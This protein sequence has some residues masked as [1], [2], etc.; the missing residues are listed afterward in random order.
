M[1]SCC[2]AFIICVCVAIENKFSREDTAAA[3]LQYVVLDLIQLLQYVC[4]VNGTKRAFFCGGFTAHPLVRYVITKEL[5]RRNMFIS[6]F[7]QV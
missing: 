2:N 3:W 6:L 1:S 7:Q 4:V 5:A